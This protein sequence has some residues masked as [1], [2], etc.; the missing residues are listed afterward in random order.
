MSLRLRYRAP[1]PVL[2][3]PKPDQQPWLKHLVNA[4]T[5]DLCLLYWM[6]SRYKLRA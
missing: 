2:F 5:A 1:D 6:I 4:S 3:C